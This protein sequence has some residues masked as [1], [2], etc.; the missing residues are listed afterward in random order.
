[1]MVQVDRMSGNQGRILMFGSGK[2]G[3]R[4]PSNPTRFLIPLRDAS[5]SLHL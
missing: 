5:F 1:M 4:T 3:D 2:G